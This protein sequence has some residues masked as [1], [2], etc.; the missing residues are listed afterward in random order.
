MCMGA[1]FVCV[2]LCHMCLMPMEARRV[3]DPLGLELDMVVSH[4]V[5]ARN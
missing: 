4:N 2:C 3:S 1:L 5:C